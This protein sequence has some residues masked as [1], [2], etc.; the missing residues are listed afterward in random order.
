MRII[1]LAIGLWLVLGL[2][3]VSARTGG[4]KD[5]N[6]EVAEAITLLEASPF[7]V[8]Q[9]VVWTENKRPLAGVQLE[10]FARTSVQADT[11]SGELLA[12]QQTGTNGAFN[13]QNLPA[14]LYELR[15]SIPG[16][17]WN[18]TRIYVKIQPANERAK[19]RPIEVPLT[20]TN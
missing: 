17:M 15:A 4:D 12:T 10:V 20:Q 16:G 19:S 13:F 5:D 18:V 8:L 1:G 3:L 9:G 11:P 6:K 14:G 7:R 2:G